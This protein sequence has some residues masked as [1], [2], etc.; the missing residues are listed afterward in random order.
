MEPERSLEDTEM[1]SNRHRGSDSGFGRRKEGRAPLTEDETRS[2]SQ[3]D[4]VEDSA[5]P[6][7]VQ[8]R[9]RDQG[10][11]RCLGQAARSKRSKLGGGSNY[12]ARNTARQRATAVYRPPAMRRDPQ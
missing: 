7:R 6:G 4:G 3:E 2:K 9:A 1:L 5:G 11:W 8:S 12:R 10:C